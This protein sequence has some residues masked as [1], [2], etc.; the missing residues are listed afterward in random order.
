MYTIDERDEVVERT[1]VPQSSIGAPQPVV[2]SDEYRLVL[3]YYL[4]VDEPGWDGTTVRVVGPASADEPIALV[5]FDGFVTFML[6]PPNDEMSDSHPLAA[7]GFVPYRVFEIRHS[8]WVRSLA[9]MNAAHRYRR[10]EDYAALTH[11][12][13]AFHDTTFECVAESFTL[14]RRRGALRAV[15]PEMQALLG[16]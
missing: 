5:R 7:R 15:L 13:F 16:W 8:S 11:Y 3:A 10:P 2:L 9:R 4:E 12:V 6:G 14:A 1:D